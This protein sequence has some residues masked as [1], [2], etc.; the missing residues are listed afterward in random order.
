MIEFLFRKSFFVCSIVAPKR[1]EEGE[2]GKVSSGEGYLRN[3]EAI[4]G[5]S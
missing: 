3:Y 5:L 2:K 1:K 4:T